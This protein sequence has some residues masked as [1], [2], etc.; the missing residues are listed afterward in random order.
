MKLTNE[1]KQ[2]IREEIGMAIGAA[3]LCWNPKP[4]TEVFD[5]D[6][7]NKILDEAYTNVIEA[8]EED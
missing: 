5:S 2:T 8:I 6:Q 7:A 1:V 3:S 4:T